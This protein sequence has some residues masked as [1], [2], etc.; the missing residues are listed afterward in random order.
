[1]SDMS[2]SVQKLAI[3]LPDQQ[4]V[5]WDPTQE[6]LAEAIVAQEKTTLTGFF[7]LNQRDDNANQY[8]YCDILQ[9]YWWDK[10]KKR[11]QKR[12][13]KRGMGKSLKM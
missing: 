2:P 7:E 13:S 3:H 9:H 11:F 4:S 6:N 1:M 12:L 8:L 5:V 10:K